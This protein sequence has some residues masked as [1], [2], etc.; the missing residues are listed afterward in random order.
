MKRRFPVHPEIITAA[1][2]LLRESGAP[3]LENGIAIDVEAITRDYCDFDVV[4]C[5]GLVLGGRTLLAAYLPQFRAI[6]FE[7]QCHPNRQRFSVAH[8]LGHAQLEDNFGDAASLFGPEPVIAFSCEPT[9][10]VA[11]PED[12]R[13]VGRRRRL[14]IRANQFAAHLLMPEGLV[15]NVWQKHQDPRKCSSLFAVSQE[16]MDYRLEA[17]KLGSATIN[18]A[19]RRLPY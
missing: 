2:R 12:E 11:K 9:D 7:E 6:A 1:D 8:E 3:K 19:S 14:E 5:D 10:I 16:A 4:A 13:R 15:R 18:A 17:L